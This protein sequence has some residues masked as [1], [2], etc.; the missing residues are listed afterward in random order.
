MFSQVR[1]MAFAEHSPL[2]HRDVEKLD[3]QDDNAATRLFCGDTLQ[4]LKDN[5]PEHH[6]LIIYLFVFGELIDAYQS[7]TLSIT[8][9]VQMVLRAQFF[10]EMWQKFLVVAKYPQ[11]KHYISQQCA[12]IADILIKGFLKLVIIYRDHVPGSPPLF[13]WLLTT[14]VVEHVF[15]LCRQIV[16]DF[17]EKNFKDMLPKLFIKIREAMFSSRTSDG[18]AR[19]S[20]YNHTYTDRRGINLTA[21]SV[22][23]TD[24]A[25]NEAAIRA[26]GEAESL[27]ALLGVS[28]AELESPSTTLP[29]IRSWFQDLDN[30]LSDSEAGLE[31]DTDILCDEDDDDAADYQ[32]LL[33]SLENT[34]LRDSRENEKLMGYRYARV[35]LSV[36]DQME[37]YAQPFTCTV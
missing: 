4:W 26:Y 5:H 36:D 10:L 30:S 19:A 35:A 20:V 24:E 21:L 37:M 7:R 14:E 8:E 29:G 3:R 11:A 23:P 22:Y 9:R 33:D 1:E 18:K 28:P 6:S 12:D 31:N 27:F 13:P 17:T 34:E 2:Y 16:K 15:G 25:I 32:S